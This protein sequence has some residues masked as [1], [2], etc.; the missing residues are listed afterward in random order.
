MA[1]QVI[2]EDKLD[3]ITLMLAAIADY[4][5]DKSEGTGLYFKS[6]KVLQALNRMGLAARALDSYS[7][8]IVNRETGITAAAHGSISNVAVN[9]Q[10]FVSAIGEAET[11]EYE[12]IYDGSAWKLE[13]HTVVMSE[14]GITFSGTPAEGDTVVVHETAEAKIYDVL[15]IDHDI[16][17]DP[18]LTHTITLCS[19]DANV[20]GSL[21]Y[22]KEQGLIYVDPEAFPNGLTAGVFYYVE[23]YYCC[24]DDTT[25]Q[26]GLYGFT[27]TH[28]VPAGGLV[29]HTTLGEWQSAAAE[30][31]KAKIL[32]G[33]WTTYDTIA[34]GR[35]IIDSGLATVEADGTSGTKLGTVTAEDP[36]KRSAVYC[37][38]TRRNRYGSGYYPGSDERT[39]MNSRAPKGTD[40][41]GVYLWQSGQ[42]GIFDIPST[43]NAAGNLYGM[44][45]QLLDVI[46]PVR[47]RTYV[48]A[49]DRE[50]QSIKYI[51][52]EETVFP[53][54]MLEAG[55]G[56]TNDGVYEN[57][58]DAEGNVKTVPYDYF[59]RRTTDAERVKT[60]N[61]TARA[62]WLRS[63]GPSHCHDVRY[64]S[65][66]GAL[67]Y[68][69]A[70]FAYGAVD[71]FNIV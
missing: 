8:I 40:A 52:T 53:L 30:Y 13:T 63:P 26:D 6:F 32:A 14:Y 65:A 34:N 37:N 21:P 12:F 25:K 60:Q 41:K 42:L 7:Q 68:R 24:Y 33:K 28:N 61:G 44:D 64:V 62:W 54:S 19:H 48:Q 23:G 5:S 31:T 69:D 20:Y 16:P 70:S 1:K 29:R 38:M 43:F 49:A 3:N 66:S 59:A 2:I 27:P 50:D 46:G 36:A 67:Y 39:W 9:E 55:L 71:A 18:N 56:T 47:K 15:G 51:D 35:T 4:N 17:A 22:K 11:K 57:A 10:T 45:P 58:V